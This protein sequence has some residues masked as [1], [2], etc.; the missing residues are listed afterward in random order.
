MDDA[1]AAIQAGDSTHT[2]IYFA[3]KTKQLDKKWPVVQQMQ[4]PAKDILI[5]TVSIDHNFNEYYQNEYSITI[6]MV[7]LNEIT[8]ERPAA[9]AITPAITPQSLEKISLT[10]IDDDRLKSKQFSEF[11]RELVHRRLISSAEK[12][13]HLK[14][15]LIGDAERLIRHLYP[16]EE[17]Y[18]ATRKIIHD[19]YDNKR[20]L[21]ES[22][23]MPS[24]IT[25]DDVTNKSLM[26]IK[27]F[28]VHT[29]SWD[30]FLIL[31]VRKNKTTDLLFQQ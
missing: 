16:N 8:A 30:P 26:E 17:N 1:L 28:D 7:K 14:P 19:R 25:I 29:D 3:I 6:Q 9:A 13:W 11:F 5:D 23:E 21:K 27:N 31:I 2:P 15:N 24:I 12:I 18:N 4:N 20:V 10:K 22:T